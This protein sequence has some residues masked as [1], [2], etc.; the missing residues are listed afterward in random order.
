MF[1]LNYLLLYILIKSGV[2]CPKM[3]TVPKHVCVM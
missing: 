2:F 1:I 3:K